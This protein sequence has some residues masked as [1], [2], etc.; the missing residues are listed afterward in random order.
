M[1]VYFARCEGTGLIKIGL[2]RQKVSTR[3]AQIARVERSPMKCLF[4]V[5]AQCPV[6]ERFVQWWLKEQLA[7][8]LEWFRADMPELRRAKRELYKLQHERIQ[9]GTFQR[10]RVVA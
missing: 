3:L 4:Y 1:K 6:D 2:T 10:K 9:A 7:R 8:G 5:R